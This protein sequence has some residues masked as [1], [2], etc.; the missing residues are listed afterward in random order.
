MQN[1]R[2]LIAW[3]VVFVLGASIAPAAAQQ[4]VFLVRHA[5]RQD[6][7]SDSPLSADGRARAAKLADLLRDAGIT[8]IYVTQFK[9]T[10]ETAKPLADRLKLPM[11]RVT[12]ADTGALVARVR[13]A[14]ATDRI[15]VVAHGDTL[16]VLLK[17]L[18]YPEPVTIGD[19]EFDS[20][21]VLVPRETP[22]AVGVRLR[23]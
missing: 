22:P 2:T 14:A 3:L 1:R 10:A 11:E 7:S 5:E 20:L 13:A 4:V 18:G 8:K 12:A 6:N 17:E 9:R 19:K 16:P 15:L 21:F 23:Y